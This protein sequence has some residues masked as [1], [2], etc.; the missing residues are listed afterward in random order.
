MLT[1]SHNNMT[2]HSSSPVI[3]VGA[4]AAG[5]MAGIFAARAGASVIVVETQPRPGAK[6]RMSGGGRGNYANRSTTRMTTNRGCA[7][8]SFENCSAVQVMPYGSN[9]LFTVTTGPI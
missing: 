3:V 6:I 5:L 7:N 8:A 9:L 2:P 1:T 4:G